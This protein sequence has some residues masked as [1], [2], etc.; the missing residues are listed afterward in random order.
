[1]T[2]DDKHT[3]LPLASDEAD[4]VSR[5][6]VLRIVLV[7]SGSVVIDSTKEVETAL[8]VTVVNCVDMGVDVHCDMPPSACVV[9]RSAEGG[10]RDLV[11]QG[12][13]L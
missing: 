13:K 12:S 6:D 2:V 5:Q 1:M 7:V 10:I 4:T 3:A 8:A 9:Q 11:P